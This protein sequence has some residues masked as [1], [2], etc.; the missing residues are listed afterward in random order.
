M[1]NTAK[2]KKS[3]CSPPLSGEKRVK[4]G[5]GKAGHTNKIGPRGWKDKKEGQGVEHKKGPFSIVL[6]ELG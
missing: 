4:A 5:A 6:Y 1:W 3:C 2:N